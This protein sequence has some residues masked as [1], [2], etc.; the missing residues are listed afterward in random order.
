MLNGVEGAQAASSPRFP[1]AAVQE[2]HAR[3]AP[4]TTLRQVIH[5]CMP[6]VWSPARSFRVRRAKH[7]WRAACP[8]ARLGTVPC[9]YIA[10]RAD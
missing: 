8:D 4:F 3:C 9:A 2:V 1:G 7:A 6:H 5:P 10:H